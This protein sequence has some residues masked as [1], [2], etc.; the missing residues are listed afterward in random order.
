[1]SNASNIPAHDISFYY[2]TIMVFYKDKQDSHYFL[3]L[4][5]K[6]VYPRV[7][8]TQLNVSPHGISHRLQR[9]IRVPSSTPDFRHQNQSSEPTVMYKYYC[10]C[11]IE[12]RIGVFP[13]VNGVT[14]RHNTQKYTYLTK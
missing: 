1:M 6:Y 2:G 11:L 3:S 7:L 5:C 12:L 10:Y 9:T 8:K 4:R 13:G 14:I